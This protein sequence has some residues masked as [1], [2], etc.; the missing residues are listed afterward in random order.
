MLHSYAPPVA[1]PDMSQHYRLMRLKSVRQSLQRAHP[2]LAARI[3][4]VYEMPAVQSFLQALP[5]RNVSPAD[6]PAGIIRPGVMPRGIQITNSITSRKMLIGNLFEQCA[7]L[8]PHIED[9]HAIEDEIR[10]C[11]D[12]YGLD[13]AL[14]EDAIE[15]TRRA[16]QQVRMRSVL[17]VVAP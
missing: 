12:E 10:T 14:A 2:D 15:E 7:N 17:R 8:Q 5:A 1:T 9:I 6:E 13:P 11:A 3:Q 4:R 16:A